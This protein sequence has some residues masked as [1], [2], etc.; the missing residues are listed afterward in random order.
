MFQS[1]QPE[2]FGSKRSG[3]EI[4][5]SHIQIIRMLEDTWS[6]HEKKSKAFLGR[7]LIYTGWRKPRLVL[8]SE[9]VIWTWDCLQEVAEFMKSQEAE[10]LT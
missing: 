8:E 9:P 2:N 10:R 3:Q 6:I 1:E 4:Y 7:I 5:M